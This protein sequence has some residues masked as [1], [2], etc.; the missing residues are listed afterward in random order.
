MLKKNRIAIILVVL[1]G[2]LTFWFVVNNRKGTLRTE[3]KNFAVKDTAS[4]T[5]IFLADKNGR[6][7]TLEKGAEGKWTVNGKYGVRMDALQTLMETLIRIDVK[8]PVGKKAQDNVVKRL[9]TKAVKC[10]IY[11]N[12]ELTKAYY[13]GTETQNLKGT[14]M[15]MIDIETMKAMERPFVT[16][17]PG[18]EGYLTTRYF[19]EERGWRDRTMFEYNPNDIKSVRMEIPYNPSFGYELTV[20]GN[21]D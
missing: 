16:Y 12:G 20:K 2:S 19:T 15:I 6:N 14:Y 11:Q 17:I 7:L 9:A 13:V 21:N 1:M 18:F 4:I 5:K 3:M 10:E 8:E